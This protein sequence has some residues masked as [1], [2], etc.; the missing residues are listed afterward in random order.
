MQSLF[1]IGNGFDLSHELKTTYEDFHQYLETNY[2][3]ASSDELTI[4]EPTPL[5]DGGECYDDDEVVSYL[6]RLISTADGEKWSDLEN[7]LGLLDFGEI[8]DDIPQVLDKD[9]DSD[10][11]KNVY[12]TQ[13][14]ASNI[15][16]PTQRITEFFSDWINTIEINT[17]IPIKPD[18]AALINKDRDL[19]LTFNYTKTLEILYQAKN[20]CHIHGEQDSDLLFGH[21]N[22]TDS[23]DENMGKYTGAEDALQEIQHALRKDTAGAIENHQ[24]FF[25][26]LSSSINKIY[27]FGFSFS[28]VD[29]VYVKEICRKLPTKDII[30]YL[31]DFDLDQHNHYKGVIRSCGFKGK[32]STYHISRTSI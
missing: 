4:P 30:W 22:D 29:Q 8:F 5:P 12:N 26:I 25:D 11:W 3:D 6:L 19:F 28:E 13:D 16:K 20:V 32:F 15:I 14:V 23:Y 21:G 27:S 24:D 2:P 18:F 7:S 9:G 31:N 10:P 17:S 1:I